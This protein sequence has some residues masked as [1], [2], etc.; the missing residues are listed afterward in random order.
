MFDVKIKT[1]KGFIRL[2]L[3][4]LVLRQGD[5]YVHLTPQEYA[6]L[7]VHHERGQDLTITSE[8]GEVTLM[9]NIADAIVSLISNIRNVDC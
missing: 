1:P 3:D 6:W 5:T 2:N 8:G 9:S 7:P 4:G